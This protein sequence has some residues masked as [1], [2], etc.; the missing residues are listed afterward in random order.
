MKENYSLL[1]EVFITK[2]GMYVYICVHGGTCVHIYIY[3]YI[4]IYTLNVYI[5][6]Y[7]GKETLMNWQHLQ[8]R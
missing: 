4:Y 1:C 3:I 7:L 6:I 2:V 8:W 5:N